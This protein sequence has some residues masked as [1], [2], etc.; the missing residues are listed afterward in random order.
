MNFYQCL[1]T[2][3]AYWPLQLLYQ[4][5]LLDTRFYFV[6]CYFWWCNRLLQASW[7]QIHN[8]FVILMNSVGQEFGQAK[9]KCLGSVPQWL[10]TQLN[11]SSWRRESSGSS[12]TNICEAQAIWDCQMQY[13]NGWQSQIGD[14]RGLGFL[15]AWKPQERL[16]TRWL[17]TPRASI[18][19]KQSRSS[20]IF[21][22]WTLEVN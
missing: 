20:I 8:H 17:K 14:S 6:F 3:S 11:I 9:Q 15:A 21:Y 13:H 16:L 18:S 22:N 19:S 2:M 4:L 5:P 1:V 7:H 10:G 12:S